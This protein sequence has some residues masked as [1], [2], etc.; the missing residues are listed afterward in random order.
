MAPTN[1][2]AW[3][4]E[5]KSVPFTIKEA[6]YTA[7]EKNEVVIKNAACAINPVD[8][9]MEK[10][11][12]FPLKYPVILGTDIAGEV[13]EVGSDVKNVK[14]GDKAIGHC[15]NLITS[16]PKH[17]AFQ[18]Y[19][20]VPADLV[21][22][23]PSSLSATEAAVMPLAISTAVS[24]LFLKGF[25]EMPLPSLKPTPSDKAVLIWG[26][27]GSVGVTAVQLA[28]AAGVEVIAT[29]SKANH[30]LV[31]S[32]GASQVLDYKSKTIEDEL[33]DAC[34]GKTLYGAYDAAG[35]PDT[36]RSCARVL[37]KSK[38]EKFISSVLGPPDDGNLEGGVTAKWCRAFEI[39][40][41]EAGDKIWGDYVPKAL[42]QGKLK[43][44]PEALVVGKGLESCQAACDRSE[45]GVSGEKVVFTL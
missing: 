34:K 17:G 2:G 45:K 10:M 11:A 15:V 14:K 41:T 13:V 19:T 5:A 3:T 31:K 44:L 6:A 18:H 29:A 40:G 24:G 7:P 8:W 33:I 9:K 28:A 16:D 23:H 37:S 1:T 25:L 36:T 43:C 4:V 38:G 12:L 20:V 27:S 35:F 39:R 42:E 32:A 30:A 26:A 21:S 22:S